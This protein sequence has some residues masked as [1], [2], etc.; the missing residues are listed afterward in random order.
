MVLEDG[1]EET[2]YRDCSISRYRTGKLL[3]ATGLHERDRAG[4]GDS[5]YACR[6]REG[7][8]GNGRKF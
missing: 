5:A 2:N 1:Y 8:K 3:D 6:I 4:W 7:P